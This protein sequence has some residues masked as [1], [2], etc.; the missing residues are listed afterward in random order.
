MENSTRLIARTQMQVSGSPLFSISEFSLGGPTQSRAF[1]VSQ[2]S[3]DDGVVLGLY[4]ILNPPKYFDYNICNVNLRDVLSPFM[5]A[6]FAYIVAKS[7]TDEVSE[8]TAKLTDVG[9]GVQ[10]SY[11]EFKGNI[12]VTAPTYSDFSSSELT[13]AVEGS[14]RLVFDVQYSF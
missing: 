8:S 13:D 12:L 9:A 4:W 10:H 7:L 1:P 2:F 6:D 3:G 14:P 11:G 5:F